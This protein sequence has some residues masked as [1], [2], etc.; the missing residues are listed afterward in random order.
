MTG[1]VRGCFGVMSGFDST[2]VPLWSLSPPSTCVSGPIGDV[3]RNFQV[4]DPLDFS[5]ELTQ[6][7]PDIRKHFVRCFGFYL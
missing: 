7:I 3:G 5:A 1:T 6:H 2:S 4:F